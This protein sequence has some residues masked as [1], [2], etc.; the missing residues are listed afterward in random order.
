[1]TGKRSERRLQFLK[2]IMLVSST[3]EQTFNIL[4]EHQKILT[5]TTPSEDS[6][7]FP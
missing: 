3:T 1:M 6:D 7:W 4:Q 5:N 2:H